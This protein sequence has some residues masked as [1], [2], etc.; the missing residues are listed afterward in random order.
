VRVHSAFLTAPRMPS[1]RIH[2]TGF[3]LRG[4]SGLGVTCPEGDI[5]TANGGCCD[6][7]NACGAQLQQNTQ[8]MDYSQAPG[9]HV[10]NL[11]ANQCVLDNGDPLACTAIQEC[12]P[13]TG[14][15]HCQYA[16]PGQTSPSQTP[17]PQLPF[18]T[19]AANE[20]TPQT[21]L[22]N[23]EIIA[24]P[25]TTI[26]TL[27]GGTPSVINPSISPSSLALTAQKQAAQQNQQA[28]AGQVSNQQSSTTSSTTEASQAAPVGPA[29]STNTS[30]TTTGVSS[31]ANGTS[32]LPDWVLPVAIAAGGVLILVMVMKK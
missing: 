20:G 23:G 6:P 19:G 11:A 13:I 31:S 8:P 7:S 3:R 9:C 1:V 21:T 14:T 29:P 5:P 32:G 27:T 15:T 12:D 26:P 10:L 2:R 22:P 25:P 17:N 18:C 4:F 30:N 24:A 28:A 16:L